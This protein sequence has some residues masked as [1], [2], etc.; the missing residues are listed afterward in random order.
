MRKKF[1]IFGDSISTLEGYN[2]EKYLLFY[3]GNIRKN[4]RV[5]T[6]DDTW[7]GMVI[8]HFDG[9]LLI[10]DS[11]SGSTVSCVYP[12]N[13]RMFPEACS[14]ERLHSL[15]NAGIPDILFVFLGLNDWDAGV[16]VVSEE[17]DEPWNVSFFGAYDHILSEIRHAFPNT[18]I[19]CL[20]LPYT[21]KMKEE[22]PPAYFKLLTVYNQCIRQ[23]AMRWHCSIA[24][25]YTH[26]SG[27]STYDLA[28]PDREGMNR[29]AQTVIMSMSRA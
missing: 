29:I 19:W 6:M 23:T 22:Y 14:Q 24:D 7:W 27:Y 26:A 11:Y 20:N 8:R 4:S 12:R 15:I 25:L 1:S 17:K 18:D 3:A 16:P 2:P 10:N 28:H 9:S 5:L 21:T 13:G